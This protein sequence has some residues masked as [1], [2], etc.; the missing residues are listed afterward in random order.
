MQPGGADKVGD[1]PSGSSRFEN[2]NVANKQMGH[3]MTA[4]GFFLL[5]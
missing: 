5:Q 3:D 1:L 2:P 4:D